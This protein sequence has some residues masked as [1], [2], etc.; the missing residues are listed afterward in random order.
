MHFNILLILAAFG[1]TVVSCAPVNQETLVSPVSSAPSP[2]PSVT[3]LVDNEFTIETPTE[4]TTTQAV[5]GA[6]INAMSSE[7]QAR[8][9]AMSPEQQ[10]QMNAIRNLL[11]RQNELVAELGGPTVQSMEREGSECC[12]Y[13]GCVPGSC[14]TALEIKPAENCCVACACCIPLSVGRIAYNVACCPARCGVMCCTGCL[15]E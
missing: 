5:C 7:Q 10:A 9:N 6:P 8:W 12:P 11:I 1:L 4:A 15:E 3:T 13:I 14:G 2:A